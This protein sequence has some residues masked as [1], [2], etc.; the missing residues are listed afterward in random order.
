MSSDHRWTIIKSSDNVPVVIG[1][2]IPQQ[3]FK[4]QQTIRGFASFENLKR[5]GFEFI[6]T[7]CTKKETRHVSTICDVL[8]L[9]HHHIEWDINIIDTITEHLQVIS[10]K[11][12]AGKRIVLC[13]PNGV[14]NT[15]IMAGALCMHLIKQNRVA[16]LLV[17]PSDIVPMLRQM[18]PPGA[19]ETLSQYKQ[20]MKIIGMSEEDIY[21]WYQLH[22]P[23]NVVRFTKE[24]IK[25][26]AA[27]QSIGISF[28]IMLN[29]Y[30]FSLY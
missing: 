18:G 14:G 15:A 26:Y 8:S 6:V 10:E 13:C 3:I 22:L 20:L 12:H 25:Q 9:S 16:Q 5:I 7:C 28:P 17:G 27:Y 21:P 30:T 11:I 2:N 24:Y 1:M 23:Q 4:T 29:E 19:V